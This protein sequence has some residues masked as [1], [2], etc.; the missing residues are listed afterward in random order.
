MPII[1]DNY[2]YFAVFGCHYFSGKMPSYSAFYVLVDLLMLS[3]TQKHFHLVTIL[4][5]SVN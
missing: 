5:T 3:C 4:L 1:F 2:Q